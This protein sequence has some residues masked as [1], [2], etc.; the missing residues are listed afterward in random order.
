MDPKVSVVVVH[1][2]DRLT[3]N[4]ADHVAIRGLLKSPGVTVASVVEN[5]DGSNSGVLVEHI[6]VLLA[7]FYSAN[8]SEKVK[9]GM[10]QRVRKGGWPHMPPR[11]YVMAATA[12]GYRVPT[13]D[14]VLAPLIRLA[15]QRAALGFQTLLL[16]RHELARAGL[17]GREGKPL[18][19]NVT[20]PLQPLHG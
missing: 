15:F 5:F 2:I 4:L 9:K 1:K 11:G 14:P 18:A 16:F 7:E 13:P 10:R 17:T 19:A 12:A 8:L 20:C 6:M 3:R